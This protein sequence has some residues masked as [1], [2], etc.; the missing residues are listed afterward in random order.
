M[1]SYISFKL[2]WVTDYGL[3]VYMVD[4]MYWYLAKRIPPGGF[5]Q[6]VLENN[7]V[8]AFGRADECNANALK[9]YARFIYNEIPTNSWGS[10]TTV[11]TWLNNQ[12]SSL[13]DSNIDEREQNG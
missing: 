10:A 6:A 12:E 7:L 3:P 4:Q 2:K 11:K 5:L 13:I 1:E 9:D 8:E